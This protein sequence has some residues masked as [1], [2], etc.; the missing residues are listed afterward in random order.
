MNSVVLATTFVGYSSS[1]KLIQGAWSTTVITAAGRW[2]KPLSS[3]NAPEIPG[4]SVPSFVHSLIIQV[5][6]HWGCE[7]G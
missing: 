2:D 4:V 5:A 6:M 1:T 7:N 3:L